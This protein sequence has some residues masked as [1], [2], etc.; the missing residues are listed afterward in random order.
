[1]YKHDQSFGGIYNLLI[2]DF[3]QLPV[4]TGRDLWG[5]MYGTVSGNDGTARELFQQFCVMELTQ[6]IQSS[7]CMIH[8]QRVAGF[9]TLPQVYP[10]GPKWTAEDNKV[11]KPITKDIVD[12][13]THELT[14]Q[15]VENNLSWITKSTCIVTSN[16]DR[17]IINAE[18]AKAFGKQNNVPVLQWRCKLILDFP[19]AAEAILYDEDERPELFAYFVQGG[20][21][22]V[23]DNAHGN[24]YFGV[25]NGTACTMHSLAWDD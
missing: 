5:V 24:V 15:D 13:V 8:T 20:C 10:L 4:T 17:A 2:G 22:Q 7:E 12:G 19:I 6:N 25:A 9:H 21:G 3:I 18:V 16:V 14:K 23:L 11:Y 1:M